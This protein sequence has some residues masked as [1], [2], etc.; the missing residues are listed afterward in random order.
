[1]DKNDT[2]NSKD[3]NFNINEIGIMMNRDNIKRFKK[4]TK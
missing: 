3:I 2:S 1:M 4:L